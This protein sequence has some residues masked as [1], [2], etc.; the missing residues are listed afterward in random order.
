[1]KSNGDMDFQTRIW[2]LMK[3]VKSPSRQSVS[4]KSTQSVLMMIYGIDGCTFF[5][6]TIGLLL[7]IL[8]WLPFML[9]QLL[10]LYTIWEHLTISRPAGECR[11]YWQVPY[12][13]K[14]KG[15]NKFQFMYQYTAIIL[16]CTLESCLGSSSERQYKLEWHLGRSLMRPKVVGK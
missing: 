1:M 14:R 11:F 6:P 7:K 5:K 16:K 13:S 15:V 3:T 12:T 4:F 9:H 10:T 2:I 8:N